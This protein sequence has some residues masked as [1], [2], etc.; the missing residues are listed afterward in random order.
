MPVAARWG[1][2]GDRLFRTYPLDVAKRCDR[3]GCPSGQQ[4]TEVLSIFGRWGNANRAP[5]GYHHI[6]R[7]VHIKRAARVEH[8]TQWKL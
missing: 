3:R 7:M 1:R 2:E 8:R 6:P 4:P 5:V